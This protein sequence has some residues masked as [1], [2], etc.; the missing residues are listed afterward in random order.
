MSS[1]PPTT[2]P[3]GAPPPFP[4]YDP[5]TQWRVYREQQR[6]A[7]RAQRDA[8][9]AQSHAWKAGYAG[10]YGPRVPSA[11]G[12]IILIGIGI[13]ALLLV[14]GHI[15]AGQFWS[16][17]GHWW[18]LLLIGA[19]L[20]L[21]GEWAMDLRRKTPVRRG[22]SFVGLL[23]VLTL[24]GMAAAGWNHARSFRQFSW[25]DDNEHG[26]NDNF[27]NFLGLPEHD[28]DQQ[29]LNAQ[30]PA[31]ASIE[32][33]NPRGDVS[34]AAGDGS[35]IEVQAHEV[36]YAGSD[37]DAKKI[38]DAE[39][40]QLRVSGSA[41]LVKS[42]GNS[43]GR[44]NLTV[45]VPKTAKVTVD[46]GKGDVTAAGLGAGLSLT[47]HGDVRLNSISGPV[48]V[49]FTSGSHDF[50]V[51]DLQGDLTIDGNLNDITL[52]EI[53]GHLAQN[54]EIFG[55]VHLETVAGPI[56]LHTSVTDLEVAELPGDLTLD[57]DNLRV[58]VAKG[59]VRVA[60]H[61]KDVDLNQIYGDISVEDRDGSISVEPAGVYGVDA[62]NSKGDVE[63]TLPPDASATV[64]ARTHNG[65]I[66]TD[67]NL[68]VSGDENKTLNGQIGSGKSRIVLSADNGD[69]RI[70]KGP[71]FPPEPPAF[72]APAPP[73][74]GVPVTPGA[75][76]L[77]TPKALPPH[78]VTQ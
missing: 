42:A 9:K 5:K 25:F 16:W 61:S 20:A 63:V 24:L 37:T 46:S 22:G 15:N 50:S 67:F 73:R 32:I 74:N 52:S 11:V 23:I 13:I 65:D 77:K 53:K 39:A 55:D 59:Q 78:P 35:A 64:I 8:W 54:G 12:P 26:L 19:G 57:S 72:S 71:G 36:A 17:Y 18:P 10:A 34:I 38:F 66:V 7:W 58:N 14:T 51:H 60:T 27:F 31:N 49:R 76:H 21:L 45:T 62:K 28:F 2:P 1:V 4:P 47:A 48:A 69:V 70:K 75:P 68:P 56:H 40:A 29:L 3:G 33:D 6:A 30:I 44:L 41:V 43:S